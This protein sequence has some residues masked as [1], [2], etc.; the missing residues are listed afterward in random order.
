MQYSTSNL[1]LNLKKKRIN[2]ET[3]YMSFVVT[4]READGLE[5]PCS[6]RHRQRWDCNT[7]L[8]HGSGS[9]CNESD[10][11]LETEEARREVWGEM[12]FVSFRREAE[13]QRR[14]PSWG[15]W[16]RW[17]KERGRGNILCLI[18]LCLGIILIW[19]SFF[20][21]FFIRIG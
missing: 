9:L 14:C 10:L 1:Q 20:L 5:K 18:V 7:I 19:V 6:W 16:H 12:K 4:G 11:G 2:T 13:M 8:S 3:E 15:K 17:G 21:F